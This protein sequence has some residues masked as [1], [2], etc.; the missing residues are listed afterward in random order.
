MVEIRYSE[1]HELSELTGRS[2]AEVREQYG[3]EF[4][5]PNKAAA[6]LNGK[7]IRTKHE[8][9]TR[10]G[11]DDRLSFVN[12]SGKR[13]LLIGAILLALTITGGL[14][15]YTATTATV[16]L[17]LTGTS[18]FASVTATG[19]PPTWTVW[20]QYRG[21]VTA[22]DLF[23]VTPEANFTGDMVVKLTLA[24]AQDLVDTYRTLVLEI[25]VYDSQATPVQAGTTEY[26]TLG[27]GDITIEIDQTGLTTPYTVELT[28]GSYAT[29]RGGWAAGSEDPN[30]LCE[31]IQK[32]S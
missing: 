1:K 16:S 7:R 30:I 17:A 4:G 15:A 14:F 3:T 31:V 11:V 10:L 18:D 28:A 2:V 20:G 24:N 9:E 23:T 27:K 6:R 29:N 26:L 22:G 25:E 5:I 12:K 8:S 21:A 32:G 19:A 13:F